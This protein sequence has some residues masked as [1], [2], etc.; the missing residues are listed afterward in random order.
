MG[1]RDLD[2]VIM[3]GREHF[4]PLSHL[5]VLWIFFSF[6]IFRAATMFEYEVSFLVDG[7]MALGAVLL[8]D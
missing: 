4:Y 7:C 2:Q 5:S 1:P 8:I 3:L 6:L